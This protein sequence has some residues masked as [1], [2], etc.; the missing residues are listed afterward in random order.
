[1]VSV[2]ILL[3]EKALSSQWEAAVQTFYTDKVKE[4]KEHRGKTGL[5]VIIK[6]NGRN[7]EGAIWVVFVLLQP[8]Y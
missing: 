5:E 7:Q 3:Q 2:D 8:Q 4:V 6:W 1:M